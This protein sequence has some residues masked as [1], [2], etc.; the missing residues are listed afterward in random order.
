MYKNSIST[1][2][3]INYFPFLI[4]LQI[5][6]NIYINIILNMVIIFCDRR[7]TNSSSAANYIFNNIINNCCYTN[8]YWYM[9]NTQ[10]YLSGTHEFNNHQC[11]NTNMYIIIIISFIDWTGIESIRT[12]F[13]MFDYNIINLYRYTITIMVMFRYCLNIFNII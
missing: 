6:F 1:L 11:G 5:C 4:S 10:G 12:F 8:S 9:D 2:C 3:I 7:W 13:N